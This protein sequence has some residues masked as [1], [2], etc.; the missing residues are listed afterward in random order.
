MRPLPPP[1]IRFGHGRGSSQ[2]VRFIQWTLRAIAWSQKEP[3]YQP[4][5]REQYHHNYPKQFLVIGS[6]TSGE[7]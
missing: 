1:F 6:R 3:Q 5:K 4:Q 2:T 7:Y